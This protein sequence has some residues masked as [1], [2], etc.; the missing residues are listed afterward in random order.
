QEGLKKMQD[1][2]RSVGSRAVPGQTDFITTGLK[3]SLGLQNIRIMGVPTTTHFAQVLVEADYRMKL[4][5]IGLEQPPVKMA[6]YVQNANPAG[7]SRNALQR[8]FFVPDYKCV[9]VADD[10][11]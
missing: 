7:V 10:A 3:E 2:L 6:S 5:G 1:F 9:R 4:I 11:M 8:W